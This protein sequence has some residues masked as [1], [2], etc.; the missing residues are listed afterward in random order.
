MPCRSSSWTQ[1]QT[2]GHSGG[3][4]GCGCG[5]VWGVPGQKLWPLDSGRLCLP[6]SG[7]LCLPAHGRALSCVFPVS[8]LG[9][10][11]W[12]SGICHPPSP[13]P[14]PAAE[15][16]L[17]RGPVSDP[18]ALCSDQPPPGPTQ[19]R[20]LR[21]HMFLAPWKIQGGRG[22]GS[23]TGAEVTEQQGRCSWQRQSQW[24]QVLL[25]PWPRGL[26]VHGLRRGTRQ[27]PGR[28]C[29]RSGY[30]CSTAL[31]TVRHTVRAEPGPRPAA[32]CCIHGGLGVAGHADGG[33]SWGGSE[34]RENRLGR[35]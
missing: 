29:T 8:W 26:Q 5:L 35:V 24:G 21:T 1:G 23:A 12:A 7:R 11:P 30:S 16:G 13:C 19:G 31:M 18:R 17:W 15:N 10:L 22:S 6:D 20:L 34:W 9:F 4:A 28:P 25:D 14:L 33:Q 27:R 2:C 32:C 3:G